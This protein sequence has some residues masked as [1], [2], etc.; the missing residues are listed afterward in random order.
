GAD[1]ARNTLMGAYFEP[2]ALARVDAL[3]PLADAL[4][5][6]LAQLAL[7]WCLRQSSVASVLVG[8]TSAAQL[9]ENAKASGMRLPC[10]IVA[11]IDEISPPPE[12]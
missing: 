7:A 1:A 5:I 12:R 11:R 6:S 3:V 2:D 10:E 8:A 9:E 4:G